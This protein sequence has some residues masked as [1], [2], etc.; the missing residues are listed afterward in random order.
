[1]GNVGNFKKTQEKD[2]T[3]EGT[4]KKPGHDLQKKFIALFPLRLT[5]NS[6][7]MG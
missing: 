2:E 4:E 3:T 6:D 5:C 7:S 1:M